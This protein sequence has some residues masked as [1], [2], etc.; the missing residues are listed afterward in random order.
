M[1]DIASFPT[2]EIVTRLEAER[3]VDERVTPVADEAVELPTT[4][5]LRVTPPAAEGDVGLGLSPP[6]AEYIVMV[7]KRVATRATL[8]RPMRMNDRLDVMRGPPVQ[9][10]VYPGPRESGGRRI[11][12]PIS[13]RG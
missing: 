1:V 5:P 3:E 9:V 4:A 7:R 12:G 2:T 10:G 13:S 6:H 8:R 11:S